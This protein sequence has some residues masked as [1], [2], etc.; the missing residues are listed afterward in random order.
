MTKPA[1]SHIAFLT[2]GNYPDHAP[3]Q[4]LEETL[5]LFEL[6]E[7]LGYNGAWVRQRHLEH[8]VSSAGTFLAAA[9]Q[10]TRHI[11][12]GTAVIQMGYESPFR[13][14]EDLLTVDVLSRGRLNVG[15]SAGQPNHLELIGPALFSGDWRQE[16]FSYDRV[17]R[18]QENLSGRW[19]GDEQT[20]I[21]SPG[22][23]QRPRLHPDSPGLI[24]RLWY[25]GGSLRSAVW[26]AEN[27]FNLLIGN[28]TSGEETDDYYTAQRAQIA[29]FRRH[30][31]Q[32]SARRPRIAAG[33]VI[34]PTDGADSATRRRYAQFA[35]SRYERTLTPQGPR[36]T[37]FSLDIVG[38]SSQILERLYNDP[39]L[40]EV[41]EL[42]LELP[43]EFTA[44][45]YR[46]I[47]TDFATHIAP[48]LGWRP[49]ARR[50][51][52]RAAGAA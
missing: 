14:A 15:L 28:L 26:A 47:L 8:G 3:Y 34:V 41:E 23:Q 6:A 48:E 52:V 20:L 5:Q 7:T 27:G 2:P 18:L 40:Q 19:L 24:D 17:K 38:E 30:V 12:L 33:R 36:R 32:D 45:E 39:V 31:P 49:T 51:E 9:T 22:N 4:G 42:R 13:L 11:E 21:A 25:G 37:L 35:A 50:E 16:D 46:Q 10:R 43:Y 44:A 29:A 1:I